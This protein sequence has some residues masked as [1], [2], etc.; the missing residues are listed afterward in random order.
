VSAEYVIGIIVALL[1]IA[2]T[3]GAWI[4]RLSAKL[5]GLEDKN[6]PA[7]TMPP[8]GNPLIPEI[9]TS[10]DGVAKMVERMATEIATTKE[11]TDDVQERVKELTKWQ[12]PGLEKVISDLAKEMGRLADAID[13]LERNR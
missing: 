4:W 9:K 12:V 7:N 11:K 1:T 8:V 13:K 6:A 5:K 3:A 2:G 10:I